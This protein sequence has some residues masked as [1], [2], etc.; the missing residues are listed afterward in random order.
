MTQPTKVLLYCLTIHVVAALL[1]GAVSHYC[2]HAFW[3][4]PYEHC[5]SPGF[6][7]AIH[8]IVSVPLSIFLAMKGTL[9]EILN[10]GPSEW[11]TLASP[12]FF[13]ST[14]TYFLV[15][16]IAGLV[17]LPGRDKLSRRKRL[18]EKCKDENT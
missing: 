12:P 13:A 18:Q 6:R 2:L 14:M 15:W 17:I 7:I 9:L 3:P 16:S 5:T 8:D 11:I 1:S 10:D 4:M